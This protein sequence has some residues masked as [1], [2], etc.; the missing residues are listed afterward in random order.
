M[1]V[2]DQLVL[3][4]FFSAGQR[5]GLAYTARVGPRVAGGLVCAVLAGCAASDSQYYSLQTVSDARPNGVTKIADAINV[6]S[7]SIPAQ[8]DRPQLVLTGRT[9][10]AVSVMNSSLWVAPLEDEIRLAV[11][12]RLSYQLGVPDLNGTG[13]PEGLPLWGVRLNVQRF[14]AVFDKYVQ[15]QSSWRL[16]RSPEVKG[17]GLPVVCSASAQVPAVG[18][19]DATVL[20]YRRALGLVSDVIAAQVAA[21]RLGNTAGIAQPPV[22]AASGLTWQGCTPLVK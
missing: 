4:M 7:V 18:G 6:Q 10:E 8:V 5:H 17:D 9:D 16:S 20:G 11:A 21:A 2:Y 3:R 19:V 15:V 12:S 1:R 14:D 22:D 13:V